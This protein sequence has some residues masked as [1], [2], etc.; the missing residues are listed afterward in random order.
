[1]FIKINFSKAFN[2]YFDY[3]RAYLILRLAN[4]NLWLIP[5][6]YCEYELYFLIF[7]KYK[8]ANDE[9]PYPIKGLLLIRLRAFSNI[10]SLLEFAKPNSENFEQNL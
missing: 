6:R 1:M 3:K 5:L 4:H 2:Y 9:A 7:I 8:V 10:I